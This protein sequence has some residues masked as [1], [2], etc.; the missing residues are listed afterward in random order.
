[1]EHAHRFLRR[2]MGMDIQKAQ[3]CEAPINFTK[4]EINT[5]AKRFKSLDSDNKGYIT[6]ND[7]RKYFKASVLTCVI[8]G[9]TKEKIVPII[10]PF[11][12]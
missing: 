10:Q 2:E 5:F 9:L 4:E 6:V 8:T 11:C 1:M 12:P 3:E 7:L